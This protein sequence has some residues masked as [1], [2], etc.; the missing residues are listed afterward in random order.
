MRFTLI[1]RVAS[2][3]GLLASL[4]SAAAPGQPAEAGYKPLLVPSEAAF[5][6]V[7][8]EKMERAAAGNLAPV[9]APL[10]HHLVESLGLA[11]KQGI[12]IDLGGGPG[13]LILELARLTELHWINADINPHFFDGFYRRSTEAGLGHRVSA[14]FADAHA[15]PFRDGYADVIVSRGTYEFWNDKP[16]AFAEIHRVLKPGGIAFIGRGLPPNLSVDVAKK[17]RSGGSGGPPYDPDEA[18]AEL[19]GIMATLTIADF[20]IIRPKPPGSQ[21][22]NY[23]I[24]I[25]WRKPVR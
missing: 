18:E 1:L 3:A 9:Y 10:A 7:D 21:G 12:G 19:R 16:R 17:V 20:Q 2:L 24:W 11:R 8:A 25:Q 15:L 6:R 23:G 14:I 13:T 4:P 22:I 5:T